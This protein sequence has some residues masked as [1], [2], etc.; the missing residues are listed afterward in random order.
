MTL[1][2]AP[3]DEVE[4]RGIAPTPNEAALSQSSIHSLA[5]RRRDPRDRSNR[6]LGVSDMWNLLLWDRV[7]AHA[8][9]LFLPIEGCV[10]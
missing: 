7:T 8:L 10:R 1:E 3:N 2:K 6:L 4:R 9:Y 5:H